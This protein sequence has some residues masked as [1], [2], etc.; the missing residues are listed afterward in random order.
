M[1]ITTYLVFK[2]YK[3]SRSQ[4]KSECDLNLTYPQFFKLRK[5]SHWS[6][7]NLLYTHK[8]TESNFRFINCEA[9]ISNVKHFWRFCNS[10]KIST[11]PG[12]NLVL[13]FS[14]AYLAQYWWKSVRQYWMWK[15]AA[16]K[17]E[18]FC[19]QSTK[20]NGIRT[21]LE[22]C[23]QKHNYCAAWLQYYMLYD[24]IRECIQSEITVFSE[25]SWSNTQKK[26]PT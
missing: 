16:L 25:M 10:G 7:W 14:I 15:C 21:L 3:F 19:L 18:M 24:V 26:S 22:A 2:T 12:P 1:H 11:N 20:A 23:K 6:F 9:H 4:D 5:I 8:C 17:F 13:Y